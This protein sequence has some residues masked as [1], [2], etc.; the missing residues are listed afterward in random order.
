MWTPSQIRKTICLIAGLLFG[1]YACYMLTLGIQ[2][3]GKISVSAIQL[4][5]GNVETTDAGVFVIFFATLLVMLGA[6]EW[7]P[8]TIVH[9][10]LSAAQKENDYLF[11]K[12]Q[13][14]NNWGR[15]KKRQRLFIVAIS[16]LLLPAIL[17]FALKL[18][19]APLTFINIF[20][21]LIINGLVIAVFFTGVMLPILM[22]LEWIDKITST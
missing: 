14:N 13:D 19:K 20:A 7:R 21:Y 6:V 2:T 11:D 1:G 17:Y 22:L 10:N 18:Q 4:L 8:K 5:T 15:M 9:Q 12:G 3:S 16:W